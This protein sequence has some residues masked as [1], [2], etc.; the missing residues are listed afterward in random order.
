MDTRAETDTGTDI[1]TEKG[2]EKGMDMETDMNTDT[3]GHGQWDGHGQGTTW[4]QK[5]ID[6]WIW[7]LSGTWT[8]IHTLHEQG[9]GHILYM[10]KFWTRFK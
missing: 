1:G 10:V 3:Y 2:P 8:W 7:T 6:N 5:G 4:T 9:H